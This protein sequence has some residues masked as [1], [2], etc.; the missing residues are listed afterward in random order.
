MSQKSP[1]REVR[2]ASASIPDKTW[3]NT[4]KLKKAD[5][6]SRNRRGRETRWGETGAGCE[7]KDGREVKP[8][9]SIAVGG[10]GAT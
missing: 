8:W 4:S 3:R 9:E 6:G 10:K 2:Q 5:P 1:E 7:L